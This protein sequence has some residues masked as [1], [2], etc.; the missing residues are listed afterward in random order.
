LAHADER[1]RKEPEGEE[2]EGSGELGWAKGGL[3]CFSFILSS[4]L[5]FSILYPFKQNPLNSNTI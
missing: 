4:F 3:G 2:G 5:F 1:R